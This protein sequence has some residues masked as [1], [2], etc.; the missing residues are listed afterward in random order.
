[1]VEHMSVRTE[2]WKSQ[3]SPQLK[4]LVQ[5]VEHNGRRWV[6]HIIQ[7]DDGPVGAVD[8]P[9]SE[10]KSLL[11]EHFL[12]VTGE[13]LLEFPRGCGYEPN[14]AL[15]RDEPGCSDGVRESREETGLSPATA[16]VLGYIWADSGLLGNR[17]VAIETE[18]DQPDETLDGEIDS[19]HWLTHGE[20]TATMLSEK[21]CDGITLS[22][23]ALWRA[24][25]RV[26][27][28]VGADVDQ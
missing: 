22:T 23:Y 5:Q 25:R 2:A 12:P 27:S 28:R 19:Q 1:M 4:V 10:G 26:D 7:A 24:H 6:Q 11:V 21:V 14:L 17:V 20:L 9:T 8:V 15:S 18:S 16:T 3:G 13:T